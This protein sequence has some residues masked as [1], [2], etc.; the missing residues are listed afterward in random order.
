MVA[1]LNTGTRRIVAS[2]V[3]LGSEAERGTAS[4][5]L[6]PTG[7]SAKDPL[8]L[9]PEVQRHVLVIPTGLPSLICETCKSDGGV[10]PVSPISGP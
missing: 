10:P 8:M 5:V 7:L 3:F 4:W 2:I 1:S 9:T 6:G